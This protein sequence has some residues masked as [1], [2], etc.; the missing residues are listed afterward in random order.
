MEAAATAGVTGDTGAGLAV[1]TQGEIA[2]LCSWCAV[3]AVSVQCVA[4]GGTCGGCR[5]G[6]SD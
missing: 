1:A 5:R 4:F 2:M 3:Q 6:F